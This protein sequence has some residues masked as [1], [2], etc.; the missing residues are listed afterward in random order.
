MLLSSCSDFNVITSS[1]VTEKKN[2]NKSNSIKVDKSQNKDE[3]VLS[4]YYEE[5]EL[6]YGF[7]TLT[8]ESQ[9]RLYFDII[10]N[11]TFITDEID[12]DASRKSYY[13]EPFTLYECTLSDLD[14]AHT[15]AAVFLDNPKIFWIDSYYTYSYSGS[16][17]TLTMQ[18]TMSQKTYEKRRKQLNAVVSDVLSGLEDDMSEF[19]REL[20]LH[21][22]LVKNCKYIENA[23]DSVDDDPYTAY[24]CLVEQ[25]AV[26]EGYTKAFQLLLKC[27]G[28]PSVTIKGS[29]EESSVVDHIWNAVKIG[30]KWYHTDV[31]WDDTDD[32]NMYDC[33]NQTEEIFRKS[34]SFSPMLSESTEDELRD[35]DDTLIAFNIV[36]PKCTA[37]K[38]N[39]YRYMGTELR[40][41]QDN[42]IATDLS[43]AATL[44]ETM[45]YIY[46]NPEY[47]D[48]DNVYYQLFSTDIYGFSDYIKSANSILGYDALSLSSKVMSKKDLNTIS[49]QIQYN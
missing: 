45:F 7:N 49:V 36:I 43:Q 5:L 42:D 40:D 35:E 20:Y 2:T 16:T 14:I 31:T 30:G 26:C 47:L 11:C 13:M 46:V 25:K 21:D 29:V 6:G 1:K 27:C 34:H 41:M 32:V 22:Y 44:G 48:Y 38:Y 24:G 39:Y 17:F 3:I 28:I 23:D 9:R 37:T 15:R 18:S 33:F 8:T 19:E 12:E 4:P 10:D